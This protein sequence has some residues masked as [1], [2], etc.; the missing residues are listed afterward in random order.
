[1][2]TSDHSEGRVS[3]RGRAVTR[4]LREYYRKLA[5]DLSP[6]LR[7]FIRHVTSSDKEGKQPPPDAAH[8]GS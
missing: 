2:A 4:L 7:E 5:D 8:G 1:M 6:R 3:E